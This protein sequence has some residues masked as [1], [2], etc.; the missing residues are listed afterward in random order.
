MDWLVGNY[1]VQQGGY[2]P[3]LALKRE[4]SGTDDKTDQDLSGAAPGSLDAPQE[5]EL[6]FTWEGEQ[7]PSYQAEGSSAAQA[8]GGQSGKLEQGEDIAFPDLEGLF[9]TEQKAGLP[10]QGEQDLGQEPRYVQQEAQA[11]AQK[12]E[13]PGRLRRSNNKQ[14]GGVNF[15]EE[16]DGLDFE[17]EPEGEEVD[18]SALFDELESDLDSRRKK[19]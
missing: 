14:D 13:Q 15:F 1:P 19:G 10:E 8:S 18:I 2:D 4:Q 11:L 17:L 3:E 12:E 5:L 16:Q 9:E 6:E 7:R